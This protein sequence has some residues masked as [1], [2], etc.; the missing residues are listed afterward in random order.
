MVGSDNTLD[1]QP[2]CFLGFEGAHRNPF[3]MFEQRETGV[4]GGAQAVIND[5]ISIQCAD[6]DGDEAHVAELP[7]QGRSD[8]VVIAAGQARTPFRHHAHWASLLRTRS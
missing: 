1:W 2:K 6:W 8:L 3:E 7:D 4:P 5:V